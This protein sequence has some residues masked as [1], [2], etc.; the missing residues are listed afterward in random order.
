MEWP[1]LQALV[2]RNDWDCRLVA[3]RGHQLSE[4]H[5]EDPLQHHRPS[6]FVPVG[7]IALLQ[8]ETSGVHRTVF[9]GD[10]TGHTD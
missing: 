10:V 8:T 2:E 6:E 7:A 1:I 9:G 4:R 3:C 5:R